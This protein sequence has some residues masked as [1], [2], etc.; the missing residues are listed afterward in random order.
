MSNKV[1]I[2]IHYKN[3]ILTGKETKYLSDIITNIPIG[4]FSIPLQTV[5]IINDDQEVG[6]SRVQIIKDN[7]SIKQIK[8]DNYFQKM[9]L[10]KD[11]L[12]DAIIVYEKK[13]GAL[14]FRYSI[15]EHEMGFQRTIVKGDIDET[16][17]NDKAAISREVKEETGFD[18]DESKLR[19]LPGSFVNK[20]FG[21]K[22]NKFTV[23]TYELSDVE[24]FDI[25]GIINKRQQDYMGEIVDLQFT[26]INHIYDTFVF[27][28]ISKKIIDTFWQGK[29]PRR[30][31]IRSPKR[32]SPSKK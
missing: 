4:A 19:V 17:V 25:N 7:L 5:T 12:L 23:F 18:L 3:S 24:F 10:F 6:K 9:K 20:G 28:S 15:Q 11:G 27:N 8:G 2:I 1:A 16:D 22:K 21:K 30:S 13:D 26:D 29:S 32:K 31:P 14:N